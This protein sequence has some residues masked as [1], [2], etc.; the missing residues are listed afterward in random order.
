MDSLWPG[1]GILVTG[2]MAK[3][4]TTLE[5][6]RLSTSEFEPS[7]EYSMLCQVIMEIVLGKRAKVVSS[8]TL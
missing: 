1:V 5:G 8:Y 3:S 6:K 2:G 7:T 4:D